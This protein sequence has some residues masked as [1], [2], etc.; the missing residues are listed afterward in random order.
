MLYG[1][2]SFNKYIHLQT[3]FYLDTALQI[4]IWKAEKYMLSSYIDLI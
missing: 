1:I 4:Q 3:L 2:Y